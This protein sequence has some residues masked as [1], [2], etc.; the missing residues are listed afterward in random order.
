MACIAP[1][2]LPDIALLAYL[3]GDAD[4]QVAAHVERC[5]HC[6]ERARRL[7]RLEDRL[8]AQLYRATCPSSME[9][10]EYHLGMLS[11]ERAA[12]VAR[13]LDEC[14]HCTREVVQL[15]AYLGEVG[16][17]LELSVLEQ[18]AERVKVLVAR[19]VEGRGG[20]QPLLTP[21][22]A[23][24]RGEEAGP[25]MYQAGDAELAI[26]IQDDAEHPDRRTILGLLTGVTDLQAFEVHVW[27]ADQFLTTV[28]IDELGN[29]I[30]SG[31]APATYELIV[32]GPEVEIHIQDLEVGAGTS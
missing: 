4:H 17:T 13:H 23:G 14:V 22:L 19:L 15:Q 12:A 30:I 24:V 29:F 3:G 32:S 10:G 25:Y 16:P 8:M 31:L 5:P 20:M 7:S 27:Q 26:E 18:A 21:A 28:S 6:R 9:L 11:G 2:E 1:P